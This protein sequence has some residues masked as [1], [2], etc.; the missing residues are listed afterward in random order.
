MPN[1]IFITNIPTPYR[2]S[3]YNYLSLLN[4]QFKVFFYRSTE[5]DRNWEFNYNSINYVFFIDKGFYLTLGRFHIHF[6][7]K[8]LW[9]I[10]K[11]PNSEIVIGG[12]WNDINVLSLVLLKRLCIINNVFHF[13]SEANY[14]TIGASNDN[15][16]KMIL[17]KFV[18]NSTSGVQ[19]S[20]GR[21]TEITLKKWNVR[22]NRFIKL[23]NT[24]EEEMFICSYNDVA[25]RKKNVRPIFLMPV[26]LVERDKGILNFF[27]SIGIENIKK[28]TFFIAGDGPD[29]DNILNFVSRNQ[30][31]EHIF[32]L[33]YCNSSSIV[34]LYRRCNI[35]LLPSFS[36]PSP[37]SLIEAIKM[38]LPV[39]VSERCGNH[40]EA[41]IDGKTGF[42]FDPFNSSSVL[43]SFLKILENESNWENMGNEGFNL[44]NLYFKK[45][46][47]ISR[48]ANELTKFSNL[49]RK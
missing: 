46:I 28:C 30:L 26:R 24:I 22:I 44:Y 5:S 43:D 3:F 17:R 47:V 35:F 18:Y 49:N 48:F 38:K 16:F 1:Y 37:L 42:I 23:P 6:N 13:W 41:V 20:S 25:L 39:L 33:G 8:L 21:M 10:F 2:T 45:S 34:D 32:V 12:S 11:E 15:F 9:K 29:K 14:M 19:L 4:F 7:P 27:D 31:T 40:F 36:D